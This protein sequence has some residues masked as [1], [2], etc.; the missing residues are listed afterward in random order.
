[1]G[2]A[3]LNTYGQTTIAYTDN[4]SPDVIFTTPGPFEDLDLVKTSYTFAVQK[5]K[6]IYEIINPASANVSFEIDVSAVVGA[7]VTWSTIPSG[8]TVTN[9]S[10]VYTIDGIDSVDIWDIVKAP[11]ITIPS[12]FN[13]SFFYDAAIRYT[14]SAGATAQTWQVGV[15]IPQAY[16]Q[17]EFTQSATGGPVRLMAA[18]LSAQASV[19]IDAEELQLKEASAS[20]SASASATATGAIIDVIL[21]PASG[22]ITYSTN[23]NFDITNAPTIVSTP[24]VDDDRYSVTVQPSTTL[25]ITTITGDDTSATQDWTVSSSGSGTGSDW[26]I[27]NNFAVSADYTLV[28]DEEYTGSSNNQGRVLQY[29]NAT[30]SLVATYAPLADTSL[31]FGNACDISDSYVLIGA[32]GWD[33]ATINNVGRAW[34][35]NASTQTFIRNY[36]NA[37]TTNLL[38]GKSVS[39]NDTYSLIASTTKVYLFLNSNGSLVRTYTMP[40]AYSSFGNAVKLSGRYALI[41]AKD[42]T[43]YY[44]LVYDIVA[45]TLDHTKN[46]GTSADDLHIEASTNYY[47][48]LTSLSGRGTVTIYDVTTGNTQ[49]SLTGGLYQSFC[50]TDK[51]LAI[52]NDVDNNVKIYDIR[53]GTLMQTITG[54]EDQPFNCAAKEDRLA[55]IQQDQT[56]TPFNVIYNYSVTGSQLFTN[57]SGN[58]L[59]MVGSKESYN[60]TIN[61]YLEVDPTTTFSG[62]YTLAYNAESADGFASLE[63]IQN[64]NNV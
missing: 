7:T 55:I 33:S 29:S 3:A 6:E 52:G 28:G 11:T 1:M 61:S 22:A 8:C 36:E 62:D 54:S 26:G 20:L 56:S 32:S 58:K 16:L 4:R 51:Y 49:R 10:G 21:S 34:L 30:G 59:T 35:Y 38:F 47:A 23:V 57:Y 40:G 5:S 9:A 27:D 60:N 14:T 45:N 19:Y 39:V 44:I 24:T 17:A 31:R 12:T 13:G 41:T 64:V 15:F 42:A 46:L 18:T 25:A 37:D 53:T 2:I 43:N 48:A 63:R 50:V